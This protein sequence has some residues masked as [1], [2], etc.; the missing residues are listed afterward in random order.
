MFHLFV[1]DLVEQIWKFVE[2]LGWKS[3]LKQLMT[4]CEKSNGDGTPPGG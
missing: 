2:L 1:G 4:D 3:E